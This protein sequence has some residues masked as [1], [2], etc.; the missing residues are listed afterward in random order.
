[1]T[2]ILAKMTK[3]MKFSVYLLYTSL[4][5]KWRSLL[6]DGMLMSCNTINARRGLTQSGRFK[7]NVGTKDKH[8]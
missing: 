3:I 1:M 5:T 4:C 6:S 2:T 7:G 8:S